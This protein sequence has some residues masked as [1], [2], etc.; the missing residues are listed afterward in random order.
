MNSS[1]QIKYGVIIS[2]FV[3]V[4][5]IVVGLL[6]TPWM[7]HAIGKP[8]YGLYVLVTTFMAYFSVDYG[9]W[10][11]INKYIAQYRANNQ[12]EKVHQVIGLSIKLYL[13]LD[14]F[15]AI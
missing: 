4:F 14:F 13:I 1:K 6:Y 15:I 8:N 3:I 11:G 5:N 2:Y 7:V 9:I 10:Q 12:Q